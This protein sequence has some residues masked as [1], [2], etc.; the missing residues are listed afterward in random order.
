MLLSARVQ[1]RNSFAKRSASV[2]S[3]TKIA[4]VDIASAPSTK[5]IYNIMK[6]I[7]L[8]RHSKRGD[9]SA[10]AGLREFDIC[11]GRGVAG[12]Q[13]AAGVL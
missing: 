5:K 3:D 11:I 8:N 1:S 7:S 12:L 9:V 2:N 4:S 6:I 13:L 10:A